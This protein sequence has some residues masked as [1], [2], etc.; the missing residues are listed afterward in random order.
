MRSMTDV[1]A[2]LEEMGLE[3]KKAFG[4][5]FLIN[6]TVIGKIVN[7]A[8]ELKYSDLVEIGPGLGALTEPMLAKGMKPRL[9]E[10]DKDLVAYWQKRELDVTFAD[11]LQLDWNKLGLRK[12]SLLVSNLPYQ[13]STSIVIDRSLGPQELKWMI[14]MFQKEVAERLTAKIRTKDYGMLSVLTQLHWRMRKVADLAP[15]DFFPAP[16]VASRVLFFERLDPQ[17][18]GV[19]FLKFLKAAFAMRRKLLLKNLKSVVD[20][21]TLPRLPEILKEQG[22][23][24]KARAEELTPQQFENLFK[25]IFK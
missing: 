1:K 11:A 20:K 4:Q 14:L 18:L 25:A 2:R 15:G 22:L 5:N 12:D 13:I 3:P 19:P 10:F 24:D 9:I 16:K 8:H 6:Q 7:E 21:T 23:N 17:G